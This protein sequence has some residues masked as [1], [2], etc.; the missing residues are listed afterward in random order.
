MQQ[1]TIDNGIQLVNH[2]SETMYDELSIKGISMPLKFQIKKY[3]EQNNNLDIILKHYDYLINSPISNENYNL[4]NFV[5]ESLW[6]EKILSF[7]NK[8]VMPFFIYIRF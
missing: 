2:N 5:Q 8:L 6:K 3:F 4:S 7:Q 1:V